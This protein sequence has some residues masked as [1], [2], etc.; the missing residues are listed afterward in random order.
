MDFK[1]H[2]TNTF[3]LHEVVEKNKIDSV[4]WIFRKITNE[5]T[6][7]E[8][9]LKQNSDKNTALHLAYQQGNK[10]IAQYILQQITDKKLKKNSFNKKIH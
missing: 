2:D 3:L 9:V 7:H 10:E 1:I 4:K 6:K 5:K 8:L